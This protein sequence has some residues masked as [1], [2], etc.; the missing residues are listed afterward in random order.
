MVP[1]LP[2]W[3]AVA[4][5]TADFGG[6]GNGEQRTVGWLGFGARRRHV[7]A[8]DVSVCGERRRVGGSARQ[9][10]APAEQSRA[11][12]KADRSTLPV[13]APGAALCSWVWPGDAQGNSGHADYGR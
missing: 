2:F 11:L 1:R 6:A 12:A 13:A 10:A 9:A 3:H 8:A 4:F 5:S 7:R